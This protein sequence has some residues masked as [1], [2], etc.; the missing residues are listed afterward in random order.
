MADYSEQERTEEAT[1]QRREDFRRRG[2]VA[3]TRELSSVLLLLGTAMAFAL[4][5]SFFLQQIMSS[6]KKVYDYITPGEMTKDSLFSMMGH[7]GISSFFVLGPLFIMALII[8]IG[9][10]VLQ[11]GF[12]VSEDA[13]TPNF[14]KINPIEGFKKLFSW[15]SLIEGAK[16]LLKLSVICFAV[17]YVMADSV[18][19]MPKL[20]YLAPA[21][22]LSYLGKQ[23]FDLLI[24]VGIILVIIATSDYFIQR[25]Q[26]EE[27]MKMT[28]QEIRDEMKTRE[29]DPLIK[30]RI[31]KIQKEVAQR[32]MM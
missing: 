3:Q 28:K 11:V 15:R 20:V 1:Q 27:Q 31:R 18:F 32:R 5:G 16:S 23:I 21:E 30:A 6:Y 25:Y 29:G 8:S 19:T 2:Q 13:L 14:E 7:L 10:S 4:M 12:L 26:L 22:I 24:A 17:Y 9:S